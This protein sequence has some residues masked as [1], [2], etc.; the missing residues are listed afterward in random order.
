MTVT[1]PRPSRSDQPCT[2]KQKGSGIEPTTLGVSGWDGRDGPARRFTGVL[3]LAYLWK[4]NVL[5]IH[6]ESTF[7]WEAELQHPTL[8]PRGGSCQTIHHQRVGRREPEP[9]WAVAA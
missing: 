3:P 7:L 1:F 9:R 6:G 2:V 8:H 5:A 4:A